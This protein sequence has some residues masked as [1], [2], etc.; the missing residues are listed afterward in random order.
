VN[1]SSTTGTNYCIYTAVNTGNTSYF[2][3]EASTVVVFGGSTAYATLLGNTGARDLHLATNNTV[4]LT[5]SSAGQ[6]TLKNGLS[7]IAE[8]NST[9]A[10]GGFV[11]IERSG[12]YV[13]LL[14]TAAAMGLGTNNDFMVSTNTGDLFYN[15][16]LN[17]VWY[18]GGTEYARLS[19]AGFGHSAIINAASFTVSGGWIT[20][21]STGIWMPIWPTTASAANVF[22]GN[23]DYLRKV[24]SIRVNKHDERPISIGAARQTIMGL[25]GILYKSKVDEN[26]RD[27]AGFIADDAE[28]VNP[29]LVT[30]D[31]K[32]ALESFTYD[33]VPAYLVPLAQDHEARIARL[34]TRLSE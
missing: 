24:T 19:T 20:M 13:G 9:A 14:G 8:L 26:Q 15:S 29:I 27:W 3:A 23:G 28:K 32:G 17:H 22:T 21:N 6:L 1:L 11:V 12:S 2:G 7:I 10:N 30:Y 33:R 25:K 16:Q 4:R 18:I 31:E 5:I 34:E